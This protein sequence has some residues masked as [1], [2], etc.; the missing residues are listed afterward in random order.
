MQNHYLL[1]LLVNVVVAFVW[2]MIFPLFGNIDYVI[3]FGL[4][5]AAIWLYD[6]AYGRGAYHLIYFIGYVLW[7]I[8]LSNLSL[9]KI[10]LQPRPQLDPGIVA[11]PLT[12][13][14]RLE[15]MILAS[16]ITLTPGTI[17]VDLREN[18]QHERVLYVHNLTTGDPDEFR[19][20][21][22]STFERLLLRV[23]R[24]SEL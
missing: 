16:V 21:V 2:Q 6:R 20:R 24:G 13:S 11:I 17:S 23:T 18:G 10:V 15:I 14:T 1:L 19:M 8:L 3:G 9:A 22:K 12:V 4:G 5:F 7:A